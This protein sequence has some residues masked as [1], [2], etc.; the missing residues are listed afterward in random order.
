MIMNNRESDP[1]NNNCGEDRVAP[2]DNSGQAEGR[3]RFYLCRTLDCIMEKNIR[4][5][6]ECDEFPCSKLQDD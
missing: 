2:K 5:C 6:Y 4:S 1:K 3:L